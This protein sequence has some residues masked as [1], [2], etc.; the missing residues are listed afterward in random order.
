MSGMKQADALGYPF[1]TD[2]VERAGENPAGPIAAGLIVRACKG[3]LLDY[4]ASPTDPLLLGNTA[5]GEAIYGDT[6]DVTDA[7]WLNVE[8]FVFWDESGGAAS[9]SVN[10]GLGL[11]ESGDGVYWSPI[12][13]IDRVALVSPATNFRDDTGLV[14]PSTTGG[15]ATAATTQNATLPEDVPVL[16]ATPISATTDP[17]VVQR[18]LSF[19]VPSRLYVRVVIV[20]TYSEPPDVIPPSIAVRVNKAVA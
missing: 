5:S 20:P 17:F 14:V 18:S 19:Y 4:I 8:L 10:V 6:I 11:E 2:P 15:L 12:P 16:F 1:A 13:V 9:E 7:Q 3:P